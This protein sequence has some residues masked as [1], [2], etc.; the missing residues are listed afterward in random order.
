M[1]QLSRNFS[2]LPGLE[3]LVIVVGHSSD[4]RS[5]DPLTFMIQCK[6]VNLLADASRSLRL[7][8]STAEFLGILVDVEVVT[9]FLSESIF[10][11]M[12]HQAGQ[13]KSDKQKISASTINTRNRDCQRC[14][15]RDSTGAKLKCSPLA[16]I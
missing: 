6:S 14:T 4:T 10:N 7:H 16:L 3:S 5:I 13:G 15:Y 9:S 2:L 11:C 12:V 1:L 8:R